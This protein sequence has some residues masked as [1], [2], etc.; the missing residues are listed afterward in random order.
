MKCLKEQERQGDMAVILP[1]DG[2]AAINAQKR[3]SAMWR[4]CSNVLHGKMLR[5]VREDRIETS[6]PTSF[7]HFDNRS[8]KL[9]LDLMV[10]LTHADMFNLSKVERRLKIQRFQMD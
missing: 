3:G 5:Q 10:E 6:T 1:S 2:H 4:L 7:D 9:L 8:W